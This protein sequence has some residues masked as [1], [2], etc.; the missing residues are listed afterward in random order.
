MMTTTAK[1][2]EIYNEIAEKS[3]RKQ[4]WKHSGTKKS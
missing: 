3:G 2:N 1:Y 4:S